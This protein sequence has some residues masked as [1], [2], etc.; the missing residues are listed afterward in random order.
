MQETLVRWFKRKRENL[1]DFK[2]KYHDY[3]VSQLY[4]KWKERVFQPFSFLC[5]F[6]IN[7]KIIEFKTKNISLYS[8]HHYSSFLH[9]FFIKFSSSPKRKMKSQK[10]SINCNTLGLLF[11]E[12]NHIDQERDYAHNNANTQSSSR[13]AIIISSIRT[14]FVIISSLLKNT[15]KPISLWIYLTSGHLLFNKVHKKLQTGNPYKEKF[16]PTSF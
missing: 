3:Q 11:L 5:N 2:I 15:I 4:K 7:I 1:L 13:R 10:S 8:L 12:S 14:N 9:S 6:S 16:I